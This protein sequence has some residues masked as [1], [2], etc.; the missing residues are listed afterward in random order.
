[1]YAFE[2]ATAL[3]Q[4]HE[5]GAVYRDLKPSNI[6]VDDNGHLKLTD[7]GLAA[8]MYVFEN[9]RNSRQSVDKVRT[10]D[11]TDVTSS[12]IEEANEVKNAMAAAFTAAINADSGETSSVAIDRERERKTL[13][14]GPEGEV[15]VR[16]P[17]VNYNARQLSNI[18]TSG[19]SKSN[20]SLGMGDSRKSL[21]ASFNR[22]EPPTHIVDP[23]YD[24]KR[25]KWVES[26]PGM[27]QVKRKSIVGTRAYLAPE[28]L[29]QV[30]EK[31]RQG[32][33]KMVDFFALGVTVYEM[34]CGCR[35]W[36]NF[37]PS[38]GTR[39]S[40]IAD[41]FAMD[42]ENLMKVIQVKGGV[43][44]RG[45]KR[46]DKAVVML[47]RDQLPPP[48]PPSL[49]PSSTQL[50][51]DRKKF[52]PG[53]VSKLHKVEFPSHVSEDAKTFIIGLLERDANQRIGYEGCMKHKW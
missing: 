21:N 39:S 27:I 1:V 12:I 25:Q 43:G 23:H 9:E 30:F 24:D 34:I 48:P 40:D 36:S 20:S 49:P 51:H 15:G 4:L 22:G 5:N 18:N 46:I 44:G 19:G 3:N 26:K 28:M 45:A 16:T 8:P 6:L 31:E 52:P 10:D 33:S 38:R 50:R 35:P 14:M 42:S 29:E 53:Y 7:M 32:Y 2:I 41:P 17:N 47:L 37:E 11:G 13:T